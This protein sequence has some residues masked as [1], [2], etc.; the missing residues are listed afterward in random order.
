[1]KFALT[2]LTA[3]VVAAQPRFAAAPLVPFRTLPLFPEE[4]AGGVWSNGAFLL[5]RNSG[6]NAPLLQAY[7]R[8]GK[9]LQAST[10]RIAGAV[11]IN[12]YPGR[13]SRATDGTWGVSGSAYTNDSRAAVFAG[14]LSP[15]G[16]RQT[17][18]RTSPYV[19]AALTFAPDGTIW[20]AGFEREAGRALRSDHAIVR[21]FDRMGRVL[22]SAIL[23]SSIPSNTH[24]AAESRL[25]VSRDRLGW[26]S[27]TANIYVELSFDGRELGRYDVKVPPKTQIN[28]TGICGD[29]S[30]WAS[31]TAEGGQRPLRLVRLE[32]TGHSLLPTPS[33]EPGGYLYGCDEASSLVLGVKQSVIWIRPAIAPR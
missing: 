22:S 11:L 7:D 32:R 3:L 28:G 16:T 1:M 21:H 6:S 27:Y 31:L 33:I 10:F 15:D 19:P 18:I 29:N 26:I 5:V 23:R 14:W 24:P 20:T 30:L 17:V 9:L 2:L 12:I 8:Q 4:T 13:F 25:L